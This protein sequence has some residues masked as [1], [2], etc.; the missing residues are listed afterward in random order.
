DT[1]AR[2]I[3]KALPNAI[4]I[5]F[6]GTPIERGDRSTRL[7]FG[8]YISIYSIRRAV[9]DGA[10]V[11]IYYESRAI[12]LSV[13]DKELLEE[14]EEVLEGE[15]TEA[16]SKLVTSWAKLEKVV[17]APERIKQVSRD[18]AT[19]FAERQKTLEGKGM[20]VG[21]SRRICAELTEQLRKHLGDD[22]VDCVMSA[23]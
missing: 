9:E 4:R 11:P 7:T 21:M 22:V 19:H 1:F 3:T 8:D 20:V 18:I 15:E 6:T 17:G 5:G 23:Q 14:V 16:A 2:N 12:P 13:D 10:T